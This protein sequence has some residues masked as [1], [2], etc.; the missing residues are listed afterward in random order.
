[1]RKVY[2]DHNATTPIHPEV[3]EAI[4]PFL[5]EKFGNPSSIHWAGREVRA[6]V[7]E[8][9][10]KVAKMINA[11]PS[12][13]IF[14]SCGSEG[15]NMAIKGVLMG[16]LKKGRHMITTV[17]EH[18]AVYRTCKFLE[19]FDFEVTYVPVDSYGMIDP[20]DIRKAI[21]K[22]TVLISVMYANNETGNIFPIKEISKIA[23]EH[24]IIFHTDAV[25]V[26]G[27]VPLDVKD[28]DVD[29]LT[30]SG[31]KFN[32]PKGIGFQYIKKGVEVL[33]LI[34]GGHQEREL[35]AGTE[36][37]VG[38]VAIGKACE[39]AMETMEK[40]SKEIGELKE[41]L[42]K[43]ILERVPDTVINGHPEKRLY[44]T[45][46]ISFKY[47]EAEALL[48]ML[49]M[50]G[51]AV[52]TGSACSSGATEPSYVLQS[53]NLDPLCS[54]GALRFSLGLGNTIDDVEYCLEVLPPLVEKIRKMSPFYK[55]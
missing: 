9:R 22:D 28:L 11:D 54:R 4:L 18:P 19:K 46:N 5:S 12:E 47:I 33:P 32:A 10:E 40:K 6:F 1:M 51:I 26:V 23:K 34:S 31:H 44:N 14:T 21:R 30:A 2:F 3:K 8:A 55:K 27:K 45:S 42:E 7:E 48:V 36:N 43:G 50:Q 49:D 52:S 24:G 38:I 16:N 35:R 15:D 41:R 25:Q 17:V 29:I 39:I 53:M 20:E 37:M 13:I